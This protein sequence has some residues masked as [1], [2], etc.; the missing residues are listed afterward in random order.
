M[1]RHRQQLPEDSSRTRMRSSIRMSA[2]DD[3]VM[4]TRDGESSNT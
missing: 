4:V 2:G 3:A 1:L